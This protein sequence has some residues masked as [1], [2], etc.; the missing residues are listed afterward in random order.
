MEVKY[1]GVQTMNDGTLNEV[2]DLMYSVYRR[3]LDHA[4]DHPD[5]CD[6]LL[7]QATGHAADGYW[8]LNK[9]LQA[10]SRKKAVRRS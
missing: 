5:P 2:R 3:L 10:D 4:A 7:C 8:C 1:C 6:C 9:S